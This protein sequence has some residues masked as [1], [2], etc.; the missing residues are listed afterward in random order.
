MI[1][2]S[3]QPGDLP[4]TFFEVH[5]GLRSKAFFCHLNVSADPARWTHA[6]SAERLVSSHGPYFET[7]KP[8]V[9]SLPKIQSP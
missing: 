8:T 1:A 6:S 5:G 7:A 4:A 9:P 2:A 3:P